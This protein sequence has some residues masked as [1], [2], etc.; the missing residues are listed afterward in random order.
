MWL[1]D[2]QLR[3]FENDMSHFARFHNTRIGYVFS[4]SFHIF[5]SERERVGGM[6]IRIS[7]IIVLNYSA[8]RLPDVMKCPS[9]PPPS[10]LSVSILALLKN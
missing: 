9:P 8:N 7:F 3:V 1:P 10:F 2:E 5:E 6:R 4:A